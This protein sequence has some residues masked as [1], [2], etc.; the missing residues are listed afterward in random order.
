MIVGKKKQVGAIG[1][2]VRSLLPQ[3]PAV[4]WQGSFSVRQLQGHAAV[5]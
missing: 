3:S 4:P 2:E 1:L 5:C